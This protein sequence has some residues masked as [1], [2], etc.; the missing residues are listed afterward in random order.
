MSPSRI[1]APTFAL[2]AGTAACLA[3]APAAPHSIPA[4]LLAVLPQAAPFSALQA[5]SQPDS[6]T[7]PAHKAKSDDPLPDGKGKDVTVRVCSGCHAVTTFASQRHTTEQWSSIID[8]MVSKGLDASDA[9]LDTITT[10][11]STYL[12]PPKDSNQPAAQPA[13]PPQP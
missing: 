1:L 13:S 12:A 3:A 8:N 5:D 4:R 10:Y 9:D 6:S 7:A 11:L 2:L